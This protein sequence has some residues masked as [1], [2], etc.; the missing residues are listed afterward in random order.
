MRLAEAAAGL[1]AVA[2]G[3]AHVRASSSEGLAVPEA[4]SALLPRGLE[5]G[6]VLSVDQDRYLAASLVGA[7][8]RQAGNAALVGVDDLGIEAIAAAGAPASRLVV[9]RA[10]AS[11]WIKAVEVLIGAV[12]LVLVRPPAAIAD[13]AARRITALLRRSG[14]VETALLV[15]GPGFPAPL[16]LRVAQA[17]WTG[18]EAGH[19]QLEARRATVVA[20]GRA[21][22]G[23]SRTVEMYLPGPD[24]AAHQLETARPIDELAARRR[25]IAA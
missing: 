2:R 16:R 1:G 3:T 18:L 20:D 12:E 9:V 23:A 17:H 25:L 22:G 21:L 15:A 13:A 6:G 11:T 8:V 4:M 5:R 14:A 24:G 19:G 7:A 10:D